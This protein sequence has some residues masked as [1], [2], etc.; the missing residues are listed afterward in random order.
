MD[1]DHDN[2][3]ASVP[4]TNIA[5]MITFCHSCQGWRASSWCYTQHSDTTMDVAWDFVQDFGPFDGLEDVLGHLWTTAVRS[6]ALPGGWG[7]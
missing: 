4:V 6:G 1:P 2:H 3:E 5:M 7:S